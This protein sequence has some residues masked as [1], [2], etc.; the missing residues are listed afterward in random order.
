MKTLLKLI[1]I[2]VLTLSVNS[3]GVQW[4]YNTLN[5][6]ANYDSLYKVRGEINTLH[7]LDWSLRTDWIY[8]NN[9]FFLNN[10]PYSFYPNQYYYNSLYSP[11]RWSMF[12]YDRW[13]YN[14]YGWN[15]WNAYPW[16]GYWNSNYWWNWQ[17]RP[18]GYS[19]IYGPRTTYLG[20][21]YGRR[22]TVNRNRRSRAITPQRTTITPRST[23]TTTNPVRTQ[24]PV[25][26]NQP[27]RT[28]PTYQQ[29]QRPVNPVQTRPQTQPRTRPVNTRPQTPTRTRGTVQQR[30][31]SKG[32][33]Q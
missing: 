14:S 5:T 16:Y 24:N 17:N 26:V 32:G 11:H 30:S 4:Q 8:A 25:R 23:R 31:N 6:A 15:T 18:Y 20:N 9:H 22:E 1:C 2:I 21:V 10:Y 28:R 7:E 33:R 29:P 13:G 3:C 19:Y 12:G 27:I